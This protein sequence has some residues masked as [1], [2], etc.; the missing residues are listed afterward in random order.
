LRAVDRKPLVPK[1]PP[2]RI[3]GLYQCKLPFALPL[4]DQL[5]TG[6]SGKYFIMAFGINQS[7]L[8]KVSDVDRA[9]TLPMLMNAPNQV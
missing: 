7:R 4:F 3:I 6:D 1:I 8:G 9:V 2:I 5:F